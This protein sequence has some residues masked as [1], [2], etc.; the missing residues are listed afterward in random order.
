MLRTIACATVLM[1]LTLYCAALDCPSNPDKTPDSLIAAEQ[2][3]A[4]ALERHEQ[5]SLACILA[6]EFQDSD[7]DGK[8]HTRAETLGAVPQ[9]K[10]G[11]NQ[12]SELQPHVYG[13]VGYIRGL[14]TLLNP[15]GQLRARVRFTDIYVYRDR[16]WQAVAG[17]ETLVSDAK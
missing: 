6:D 8:L 10:P 16:R 1:L 5:D 2:S 17:Q 15:G 9:R 4:K 13:D 11:V 3:W 14:A 12:L 7:P